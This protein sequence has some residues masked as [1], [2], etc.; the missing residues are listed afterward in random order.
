MKTV[1]LGMGGLCAGAAW[2]MTDSPDFDRVV[3]KTPMEV[4]AA[5]SRLAQEG[6]IEP[7]N[8]SGRGPRVSFKVEKSLGQT[9]HY[10]IR[11]DGR[12]AVVAELSFAAAGEDGQQTRM[13]AEL[14]LDTVALGAGFQT[15]GGV[16]LSLLQ[17]RALDGEFARFMERMVRDVEAGRPI[18]P[19]G[20]N[21]FGVR[22]TGA[23][24]YETD[25][26]LRRRRAEARQEAASRPMSNARPMVDPNRAADSYLR[27]GQPSGGWGR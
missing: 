23:S 6:E 8:Q 4:Y 2:F 9:I 27:G 26:E 3:K 7:P 12:P 14:D 10:E 20:T 24:R 5:F 13:T 25:P 22:S 11:F 17:E 19:L 1:F 15:E 21:S 18:A 16:A